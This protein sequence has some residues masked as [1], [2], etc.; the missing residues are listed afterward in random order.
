M[1]LAPD[2]EVLAR[3]IAGDYLR[4]ALLA[5]GRAFGSLPETDP[6]F[7]ALLIA[8]HVASQTDAPPWPEW[9]Y[10]TEAAQRIAQTA[11]NSARLTFLAAQCQLARCESVGDPL[12]KQVGDGLLDAFNDLSEVHQWLGAFREITN[13]PGLWEQVCRPAPPDPAAEYRDR[14]RAFVERYEGGLLHRNDKVA[15]IRRQDYY[16]SRQPVFRLVYERLHP[17][18]LAPLT[19]DEKKLIEG[20]LRKK[21]EAITDAWHE[22]TERVSGKVKLHGSQR[23]ELIRRAA[24]YLDRANRAW[25]AAQ[26]L[27]NVP[28]TVKD[29][30]RRRKQLHD[31]LPSALSQAHDQPW[32]ALFCQLG[33][34][35]QL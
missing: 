2:S 31:L 35:L 17:T 3:C 5:A 4:A 12:P 13:I 6:S 30:E 18:G 16:L 23:A 26:A 25:Q 33:G 9:C 19:A 1:D 7:E 8:H 28:I 24:D 15:Y 34:C 32:G 29:V 22:S 21:P 20:W 27:G 11:P 10:D 14:R